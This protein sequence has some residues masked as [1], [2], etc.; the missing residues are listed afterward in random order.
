[1]AKIPP[2]FLRVE[3]TESGSAGQFKWTLRR[4]IVRMPVPFC[5]I[6]ESLNDRRTPRFLN[7]NKTAGSKNEG[8]E[9]RIL[10]SEVTKQPFRHFEMM[11]TMH[12]GLS[13]VNRILLAHAIRWMLLE[14]MGT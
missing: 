11:Q 9:E 7:T 10:I 1:M 14:L 5:S 6:T 8:K 12:A 13:Q 3:R 2:E 4:P